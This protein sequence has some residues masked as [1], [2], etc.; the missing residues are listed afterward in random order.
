MRRTCA[1]KT[2]TLECLTGLRGA[3]ILRSMSQPNV[4]PMTRRQFLNLSLRL[5]ASAVLMAGSG[6]A[7]SALIEPHWLSIERVEVRLPRLPIDLDGLTIAQLSDLHRSQ[8]VE[9]EQVEA[10]VDAANQLQPDLI[11]LTGDYVTHSASYMPDCTQALGALQARLGVVAILGNHDYWTDSEFIVHEL[12]AQSIPVL[13]N[14]AIPIEL[15]RARVWLAGVDDVWSGRAD[16]ARAVRRV[17]EHEATI[18]LAHEPDYADV[19]AQ[20]PI[21]LQLSGHSHGGQVRLPLIG[22]LVTSSIYGKRYEMGCYVQNGTTMYV[23]RGVGMEGK[24]APR[25]RFLCPPEI[26][27]FVLRGSDK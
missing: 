27:L 10:A 2:P 21:D 13:R 24:G 3:F 9:V 7:Y 11:V 15:N 25:M 1:T 14:D 16:L 23:S 12:E 19:A 5:S 6:G 4:N 8:Y 26:E 17:P 22:A 18:L 20:Y